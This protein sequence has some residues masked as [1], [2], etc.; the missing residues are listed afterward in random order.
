[1]NATLIYS[2][3]ELEAFVV[4]TAKDSFG[5]IHILTGYEGTGACLWCGKDFEGKRKRYC[6]GRMLDTGE[7]AHWRQYHRHFNWTFARDWCLTRYEHR[8]ANCGHEGSYWNGVVYIRGKAL[9]EAHHI[10]PMEG[11]SREWTPYNLPWNLICLCHECHVLVHAR[12]RGVSIGTKL[13][14]FDRAVV[15]G[16]LTL[17]GIV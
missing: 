5:T 15:N 13:T 2:Q 1:M 8:C 3:E 10:I 4:K 16:Q 7:E 12:M 9:L 17:G 14:K 11:E 6:T